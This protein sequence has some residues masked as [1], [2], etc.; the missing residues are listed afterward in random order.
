MGSLAIDD[1]NNNNNNNNNN[2]LFREA[3]FQRGFPPLARRCLENAKHFCKQSVTCLA[4]KR[5]F[6]GA[7]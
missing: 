1:I 7:P 4:F 2:R 6:W 3:G 5:D